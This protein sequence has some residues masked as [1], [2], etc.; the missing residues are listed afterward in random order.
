MAKLKIND[1]KPTGAELFDDSESFM[2]EL[3][4]DEVGHVLGGRIVNPDSLR[5]TFCEPIVPMT[6]PPRT[7][8]LTGPYSPVIL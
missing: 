6:I 2:N 4:N 1:I 3:V 8:I 5:E 7:T